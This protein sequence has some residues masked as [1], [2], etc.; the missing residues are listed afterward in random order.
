MPTCN[1]GPYLPAQRV[2]RMICAAVM[3]TAIGIAGCQ[4]VPVNEGTPAS[5]SEVMAKLKDDL[6]MYQVYDA[7]ASAA[8]PLPNVCKGIVGFFIDNVK[9][10]L[11]TKT[12]TTTSGKAEIALPVGAVTFGPSLSGSQQAVGT[13]TLAF[14]FYPRP[15]VAKKRDKRPAAIDGAQYPI[16]ASLQ[17][18]RDGLLAASDKEPCISL[19]PE[20][21]DGKLLADPG[22]TFA[23]GFTVINTVSGGASLKFV[24]FSLGATSSSQQQAG[25]T[26]TVTFKARPDSAAAF[27]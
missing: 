22:G 7:E 19:V 26:I 23:F 20:G 27:M 8:A 25:N 12:D 10:Q 2:N 9:V 11:T 14:A 6:A 3:S 1:A 18:L 4:S 21:P 13:Q 24:V 16:A 15:I 17:Q 5:V